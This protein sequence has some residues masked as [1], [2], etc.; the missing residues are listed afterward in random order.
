[1]RTPNHRGMALGSL[2]IAG[3]LNKRSLCRA[4]LYEEPSVR[5]R[6]AIEEASTL[7]WD[8]YVGDGGAVIGVHTFGASAPLKLLLTK[9]GLP[10]TGWPKSPVNGYRQPAGLRKRP[11]PI[12][13]VGL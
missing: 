3:V 6:V 1:M 13:M 11:S 4:F 9:F 7:G 8:H 5:P 10:P 12:Y 2:V